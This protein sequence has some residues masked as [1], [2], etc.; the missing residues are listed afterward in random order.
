MS[1]LPVISSAELCGILSK[2]G[3]EFDH[4]KGSHIILRMKEFP[5]RR[6]TVP[7]RRELPKGTLRAIL[8]QAGLTVDDVTAL[9]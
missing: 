8:R 6:L 4:Q 3:Y 1:G 2:K 7:N 9:L 5:Y